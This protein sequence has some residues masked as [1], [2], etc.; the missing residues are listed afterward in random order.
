MIVE[1]L[2]VPEALVPDRDEWPFTVPVVRS[3][4]GEGLAL[5]RP[6]T[7]VVGE[8][9]SG[10]STVVE[11]LAEAWGVDVRGGRGDS[12]WSSP[13]E[14]SALGRVL[15]VDRTPVGAR[16]TGTAARG[17]FLRSET[18]LDM[19]GRFEPGDPA[20]RDVSHGESFLQAFDSHFDGR[21]LY[22]LD[23]PEAALSFSSCLRLMGT[24][25]DVVETGGQV[26]CATHSPVLTAWP[27]ARILEVGDHG[28]RAVEWADL[29]LVRH[30]RSFLEG[31]EGYLRHL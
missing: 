9:G 23:E 10:K 26:V 14:K 12:R 3:L 18:A 31:P 25:A 1:R 17:F 20:F 27:G 13:L 5:D 2:R 8:N 19:F 24:L 16:L 15:R 11:A 22:L 30:W 6:V 4:I 7:F 29:D 21:G 28:V